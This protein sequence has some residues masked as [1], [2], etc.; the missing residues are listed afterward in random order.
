MKPKIKILIPVKKIKKRISE[1]GK[2]I[3]DYYK[4]KVSEKKPLVAIV[5]QK[6]ASIF[7]ADLIREIKLPLDLRF[8][9]VAS[10]RGKISPQGDPEIFDKIQ[11]GIGN[12]H[13]LVIEDILDTGKTLAFV[14]DCLQKLHPASLNF[15]VLL[16]KTIKRQTKIPKVKFKAFEVA[17]EFV[18][19]YGLDYNEIYRNLPYVG[20]L[21]NNNEI[22]K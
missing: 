18:I 21:K 22:T 1:L 11:S 15:A 19:G 20:I 12:D 16:I 10:Y 5:I 14:D 8:M 3:T 7:G 2:E 4:N 17:D 9:R 6:G 13:V